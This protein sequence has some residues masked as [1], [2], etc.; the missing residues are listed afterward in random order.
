[1]GQRGSV[2]I[3]LG[4]VSPWFVVIYGIVLGRASPNGYRVFRRLLLGPPLQR[5]DL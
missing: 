5:N 4:D 1:M 2:L 3:L